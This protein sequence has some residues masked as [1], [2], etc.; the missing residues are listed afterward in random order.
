MSLS[1]PSPGHLRAVWL[2]VPVRL[3]GSMPSL[4]RAR[5]L[6][7]GLEATAGSAGSAAVCPTTGN[8]VRCAILSTEPGLCQL[9]DKTRRPAQ[10]QRTKRH[11]TSPR[12]RAGWWDEPD[13]GGARQEQ[14]RWC[15]SGEES[16]MVSVA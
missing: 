14:P 10:A 12:G 15:V 13:E 3:C 11:S 8:G 4:R 16:R 6:A 5:R 7:G 2:S 1:A 9:Q